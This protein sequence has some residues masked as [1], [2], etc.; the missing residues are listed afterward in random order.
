MLRGQ[1]WEDP[2][3]N[4]PGRG[5]GRASW[6]GK[7]TARKPVLGEHSRV[8]KDGRAAGKDEIIEGLIVGLCFKVVEREPMENFKP[9]SYDCELEREKWLWKI[10]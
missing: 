9:R 7:E 1:L 3:K 2:G 10:C 5:N 4:S 6:Q 8:I